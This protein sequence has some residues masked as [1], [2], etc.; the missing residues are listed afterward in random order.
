MAGAESLI[1]LDDAVLQTK[2]IQIESNQQV[3]TEKLAAMSSQLNDLN[4]KVD[5]IVAVQ[6]PD[7]VKQKLK[8]VLTW[9]IANL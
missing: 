9:I 4:A 8:D 2:L 1:K 7:D 6:M 3:A 5:K